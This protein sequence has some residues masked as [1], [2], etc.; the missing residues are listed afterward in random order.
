MY[1]KEY[2]SEG[3]TTRLRILEKRYRMYCNCINETG[4]QLTPVG[5]AVGRSKCKTDISILHLLAELLSHIN[6]DIELSDEAVKGYERI[7]EP[8]ERHR[9][10]RE[11]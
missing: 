3:I 2:I 6:E 11:S 8:Y 9:N 4:G 5:A 10:F 7:C 1:D